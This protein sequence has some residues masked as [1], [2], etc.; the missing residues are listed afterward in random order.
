[1]LEQLREKPKPKRKAFSKDMR[2]AVNTIR[3][4]LSMV[5]DNGIN[6]DLKKKNLKN[7][8]NLRLKYPKRS[9]EKS[10]YSYLNDMTYVSE[11][12]I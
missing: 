8:I 4:S 9:K 1:M 6:L 7:I 3:Q 10:Y 12:Y 2:I 5:S 11:M